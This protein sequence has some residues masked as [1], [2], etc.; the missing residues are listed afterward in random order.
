MHKVF[1]KSQWNSCTPTHEV[2]HTFFDINEILQVPER[3]QRLLRRPGWEQFLT[4]A[5]RESTR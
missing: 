1:P 2:F 3:E 4:N 5:I